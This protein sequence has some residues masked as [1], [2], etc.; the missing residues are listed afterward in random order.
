MVQPPTCNRQAPHARAVSL[1]KY[2][3][4]R[5]PRSP[6]AQLRADAFANVHP[7][8]RAAPALGG[9]RWSGT[10][11]ECPEGRVRRTEERNRTG[12]V[13]LEVWNRAVQPIQLL[14]VANTATGS[15]AA[16][17]D[18]LTGVQELREIAARTDSEL[19]CHRPAQ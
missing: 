16:G 11:T 18:G 9:T 1:R 4:Q 13:V 10:W 7:A 14:L 8:S 3:L 15:V 6:C 2:R 12:G 5:K 19:E 17:E